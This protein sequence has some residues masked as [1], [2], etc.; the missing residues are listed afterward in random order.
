[1]FEQLFNSPLLYSLSLTL[2]HFLW[3]G[4]LVALILKSVL[5]IVDKNKSKLRYALATFA[6]LANAVLA[7][8]T[9]IMV[10]PDTSLGINS[11]TSAIPLTSL[12]NELT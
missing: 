2:V 6:M 8:L 12:V 10:Y 1:M 7:T 11:N 3:Q 4:L 9:F 5:F